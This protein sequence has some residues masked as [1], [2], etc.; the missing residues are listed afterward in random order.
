MFI[1]H[2]KFENFRNLDTAKIEVDSGINVIY[3]ANGMGKTNLIEAVW[4]L[5][6]RRSFRGVYD[7]NLIRICDGKRKQSA[8]IE[9]GFYSCRRQ[10]NVK[11]I[12][13]AKKSAVVNEV[14]LELPSQLQEHISAVVFSPADLELVENSPKERR[15]W[16]DETICAMRPKYEKVLTLYKKCLEQR[17]AVLKNYYDD[18]F[19]AQTM[20][21][22]YDKH[23]S[24]YAEFII[25]QRKMYLK[26]VG[27][28]IPDIISGLTQSRE[29][30]DINYECSC[31]GESED[32]IFSALKSARENDI[33]YQTTTV[34]AH[35]DDIDFKINGMSVKNYGSQGQKRSAVLA[36][37][38]VEA[39]I[40]KNNTDENPII[41]LDDVLSEL[42]EFR[43]DYILNK[44]TNGQVFIT[45]CDKS[46]VNI[47]K[48]GKTFY[49]ENGVVNEEK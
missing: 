2:L 19:T 5:T 39:Q 29:Q 23:L 45:C 48:R 6:G 32:E 8:K 15:K 26:A 28:I 1:K 13:G 10:Q 30:F 40:I 3:G 46:T 44:I 18:K 49:V 14:P 21:E 12:L 11:L 25:K 24:N 37:K 38:L 47:Q 4:M 31:N 20:L 36:L 33:K 27:E 22:I 9:A 41:L 43:R 34:G 42:D 16:I 7:S 17:N 35:R